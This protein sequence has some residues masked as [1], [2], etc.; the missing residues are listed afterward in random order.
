MKLLNSFAPNPRMVRMFMAE[1]GIDLPLEE[2]DL[3]AG[4][5]RKEPYTRR[6]PGA[7]MPAL[8][9]DDGSVIA[10]T[11]AICEYLDETC[12]GAP[13]MGET[14]Q[15]RAEARMW[16]RR[17]ELN[18]TEHLY[19]GFRYAE[20]LGLFKDRVYCIPEAAD[21]LK[22]KGQDQLKWLDGLMESKEYIGGDNL[23]LAD[24]ALYCCLD[25]VQGT[26]QSLNPEHK[27][28]A[29][30]FARMD[31]RPSAQSSLHPTCKAVG[32]RG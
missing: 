29:A 28:V 9:L 16:I 18:I 12:P 30:W 4:E 23:G 32:M 15:Q 31:A 2:H 22:A 27:N 13:M 11:A 21:G 20:G 26:G 24:L 1:R 17:V 5:N 8:E 7:T 6:N 3:L 14:P 25:F 19:N 10:E